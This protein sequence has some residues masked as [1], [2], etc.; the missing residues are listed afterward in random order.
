MERKQAEEHERASSKRSLLNS[1][2]F[3][4]NAFKV[5]NE[6]LYGPLN[7]ENKEFRVLDVEPG[8]GKDVVRCTLRLTSLN[9]TEF[10]SYETVCALHDTPHIPIFS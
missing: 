5:E 7:S 1:F 6:N 8:T 10:P 9:A 4:H 2:R 3:W